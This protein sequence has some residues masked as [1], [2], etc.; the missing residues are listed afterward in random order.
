MIRVGLLDKIKAM[1]VKKEI[2]VNKIYLKMYRF[3]GFV[4]LASAL[5]FLFGYGAIMGFFMVDSNWIAP[6]ILSATSDKVLQFNAGYLTALQTAGQLDVLLK[7]QQ[8]AL[9]TSTKEKVEL[10]AFRDSIKSGSELQSHKRSDLTESE[11]L[12]VALRIVKA[13]TTQSQKLGLITNED[14][15]R[16]VTS[17][18][19]FANNV[20]DGHIGLATLRQQLITLDYQIA[21]LDDA[22]IVEQE[23]INVT[24]K[25]LAVAN[26]TLVNLQDSSYAH[27]VFHG[28]NLAFV[29]YD[30][31]SSVKEGQPVYD[32]YL[33]IVACHRIGTIKNLYKD[34]QLVDFPLFN[35]RLSRQVRGVFAEMDITDP[36]AMKS[37]LV[38]AGHKPLLF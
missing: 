6:T 19:Q 16:T 18:Q 30:N 24:S 4:V 17:I 33:M 5:L 21:Q 29:A 12:S 15:V 7:Q 1:F 28:S 38:F 2:T 35:V 37:L 27:A 31:F 34:E 32:C 22:I 10:I 3:V 20:T 14:A 9:N 36:R 8:L 25:N 23:T 26:A 11:H 13:Q